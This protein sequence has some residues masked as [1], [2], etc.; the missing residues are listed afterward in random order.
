MLLP[1][2]Y[3]WQMVSQLSLYVAIDIWQMLLPGWWGGIANQGGYNKHLADVVAI[4]G[5]WN[6]HWVNFYF[7]FSSKMLNRTSCHMYGRWYLPRF[8]LRDGLL[9]PI[10]KVH[11]MVLIRLWSSLPL[12][13]KLAMVTV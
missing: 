10:Y 4:S 8:L 6:S 11:L 7:N 13:L 5:R 3:V 9:T 1:L 12:I 2:Y